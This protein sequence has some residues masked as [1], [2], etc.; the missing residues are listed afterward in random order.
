M[1]NTLRYPN[2][3]GQIALKSRSDFEKKSFFDAKDNK[4]RVKRLIKL[5]DILNKHDFDIDL[6]ELKFTKLKKYKDYSLVKLTETELKKVLPNYDIRE[7]SYL[8]FLGIAKLEPNSYS[9]QLD[10]FLDKFI[11][12]NLNEVTFEENLDAIFK[13]FDKDKNGIISKNE[14][15][16][17]ISFFNETN[18]LAFEK[19]TIN[20]IAEAIYRDINKSNRN[21]IS[22]EE[23]KKYLEKFKDQDIGINPFRRVKTCESITRVKKNTIAPIT[24]KE[25]KEM[26]RI[27]RKKDRSKLRKFWVLNKKMI[28]W[29]GIYFVLC[30]LSGI[31]NRSLEGGRQYETTKASRF[32]AGIIFINLFLLILFMCI[33]TMTAISTTRLKFYLPLNDIKHY[34]AVCAVMVGIAAIPHIILHI[35]GDFRQI[36]ALTIKKPKDAYV[37]VAWLTFLNPTG[38]TGVI[39]LLLFSIIIIIPLIPYFREKRYEI[40]LHTHKL[41]Y[42]ALPVLLI[43]CRT[44]DAKRWPYFF[45]LILPLIIFSIELVFRLV[46]YFRN[47]TK[48]LRIKYLK[49]GVVLLT[50]KKPKHFSFQCGQYAQINIPSISKWQ[51]HP[52]TFA[53]S[54]SDDHLYFYVNP[55]GDWTKQL[56]NLGKNKGNLFIVFIYLTMKV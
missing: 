17:L 25:E 9:L 11:R 16:E 14:A 2:D 29:S 44:P 48:I 6:D 8:G 46:R 39:S 28:I 54:P 5:I 51:W 52:F 12:I 34:H 36:A 50:I 35:A 40:F 53:S 20:I 21:G 3:S 45:F 26:E 23:L 38:Y 15:T 37:T 10:L 7:E 33:I 32:F 1:E 49:S 56:Q 4:Y 47:K 22:K 31:I 55:V 41:F 42:I 43:H 24:T 18:S 13:I 19:E 30:I 27:S